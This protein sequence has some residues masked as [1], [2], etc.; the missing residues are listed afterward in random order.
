MWEMSLLHSS[1]NKSRWEKIPPPAALQTENRWQMSLPHRSIDRKQVRDWAIWDISGHRDAQVSRSRTLVE[2][3]IRQALQK[4]W[5]AELRPLQKQR[6]R[7]TERGERAHARDG[8]FG[9]G[10][11]PHLGFCLMVKERRSC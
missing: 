8:A 2:V 6:Q 5:P 3:E 7:G 10:D 1:T 4:L 11:L 9:V